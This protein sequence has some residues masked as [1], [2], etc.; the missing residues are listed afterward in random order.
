MDVVNAAIAQDPKHYGEAVKSKHHQEW[1]I[2]MTE[3]LDAL[4]AKNVWTVVVPPKDAHD[5]H[6]KWVYKTKTDA[7]GDIERY[8]A[9]LRQ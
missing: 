6:N 8:K 5:L 4:K 7:N 9:R 2:A 3:E 1:K